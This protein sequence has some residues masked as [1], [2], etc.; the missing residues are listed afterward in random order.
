MPGPTW[1]NHIEIAKYVGLETRIYPYYD[2]ETKGLDI[3]G[4]LKSLEEAREKSCF[5]FHAVAHNPTGVDPKL[6]EWKQIK[7]V[8]KRRG[9]LMVFDLAYHGFATGNM[10][11]DLQGFRLFAKDADIP[12]VACQS[13]SKNFGLYGERIGSLSVLT[14]KPEEV[15]PVTKQLKNIARKTYTSPPL[16][17]AR[18]VKTVL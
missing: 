7:E 14:N 12:I 18:I 4:I 13:F 15:M 3:K 8:V 17:G 5:L 10:E 6:E 11:K 1:P 2:K 9:H 16:F